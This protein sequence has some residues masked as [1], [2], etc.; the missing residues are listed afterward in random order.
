MPKIRTTFMP[1]E[2]LDVDEHEESE[3][4]ALGV[5]LENTRATTEQGLQKAA[6]RQVAASTENQEG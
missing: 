5:V 6:Q 1:G 2:E 4:R 3:L